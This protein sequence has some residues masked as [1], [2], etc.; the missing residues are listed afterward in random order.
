MRKKKMTNMK[1][2]YIII[3]LLSIIFTCSCS[4]DDEYSESDYKKGIIGKWEQF[5]CSGWEKTNGVLSDEFTD[6]VY[7]KNYWVY[8]YKEDGTRLEEVYSRLDSSISQTKEYR[9]SILGD[10]IVVKYADGK[11]MDAIEKILSINSTEMK[12][13]INFSEKNHNTVYEYYEVY[14]YKRR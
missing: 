11:F 3:A 10:T 7:D 12:T 6:R 14:T 2:L 8:T 1:N 13:L 5:S 4:K 9:W